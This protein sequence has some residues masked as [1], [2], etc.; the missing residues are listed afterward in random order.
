MSKVLGAT[1]GSNKMLWKF[2]ER[3]FLGLRPVRSK[4]R[5]IRDGIMDMIALKLGLEKICYIWAE[6]CKVKMTHSV[7]MK[8]DREVSF[9]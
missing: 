6:S 8:Y 1:R 2:E 3:D 9:I 7:A 5:S 4:R